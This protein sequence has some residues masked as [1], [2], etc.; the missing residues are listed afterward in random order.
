MVRDQN[1]YTL[2]VMNENYAHPRCGG[3]EAAYSAHALTRVGKSG[4]GRQGS[5]G[6]AQGCGTI[7]AK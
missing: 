4:Q 2:T 5:S 6:A 7:R 3:A 1:N